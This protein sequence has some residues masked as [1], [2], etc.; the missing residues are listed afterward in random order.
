MERVR[1]QTEVG[2]FSNLNQ[3]SKDIIDELKNIGSSVAKLMAC[4]EAASK[5]CCDLTEG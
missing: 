2:S 5:R 1:L 4:F 3:P